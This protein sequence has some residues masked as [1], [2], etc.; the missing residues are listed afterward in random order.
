MFFYLFP[1]QQEMQNIRQEWDTHSKHTRKLVKDMRALMQ[2]LQ[3][4]Q[5]DMNQ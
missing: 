3:S 4:S 1:S 2:A 5:H